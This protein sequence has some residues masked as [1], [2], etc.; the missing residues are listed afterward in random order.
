M[1][2]QKKQ[3]LCAAAAL[4]VS[5]SS[6]GQFFT[7]TA[8]RGA[9]GQGAGA[10]WMSG[11]TNFDPQNTVYPGT[12]S[13][14]NLA[15]KIRV[16]VGASSPGGTGANASPNTGSGGGAGVGYS[17]F[18]AAGSGAAGIVVIQYFPGTASYSVN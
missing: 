5:A 1:K 18:T 14:E 7:T 6:F 16:D 4:M 9:F 15:G 12:G 2:K 8:Y 11:W 10:N 17:G 13:G 3:L